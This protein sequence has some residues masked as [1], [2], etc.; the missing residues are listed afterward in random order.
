MNKV[1]LAGRLTRDPETGVREREG[2]EITYS[3]YTL[4]ATEYHGQ[5]EFIPCVSF[6]KNAAFANK[7]FRKGMRVLVEGRIHRESFT[8][9]DG[10][11]I[12]VFSVIVQNQE[13][14][15]GKNG[16]NSERDTENE[17]DKFME[18]SEDALAEMPF[19]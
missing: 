18:I 10:T 4:A 1:I 11:T 15:D 16:G 14:A 5:P 17:E 8:G 2:K 9:E 19:S 6:Q 3:R 12:R 13:F 7:Y